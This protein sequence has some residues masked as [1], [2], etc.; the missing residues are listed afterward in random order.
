MRAFVASAFVTLVTIVLLTATVAHAQAPTGDTARGK[1]LYFRYSCFACHGYDG[2]GGAG[3]RLV[4]F[5]FTPQRFTAFVR[6][7]SRRM[8]PYT[9]KVLTDAQVADLFAYIKSLP[10]SPAADQIPLLKRI[11]EAK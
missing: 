4:P 6:S 3:A 11:M 5:A 9:D 8:P 10:A 7:P 2:H 1:D